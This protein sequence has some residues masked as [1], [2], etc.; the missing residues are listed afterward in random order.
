ML[1]VKA[2]LLQRK[3]SF[4]CFSAKQSE[5]VEKRERRWMPPKSQ[6]PAL[7]LSQYSLNYLL[8]IT[9]RETAL[10]AHCLELNAPPPDALFNIA[11][12]LLS[13]LKPAQFRH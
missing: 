9:K 11:M 3:Q 12:L 6:F 7:T 2:L 13:M 4:P 1:I 5:A 10:L 8:L